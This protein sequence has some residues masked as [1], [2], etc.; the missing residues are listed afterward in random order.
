MAR[1]NPKV[2]LVFKKLF[3]SEENTDILLSLINSILPADRQIAQ[4]TLKNPYN[5][6]DY[7]QGKLSILDIKAEDEHGKQYDIEMQLQGSSFYG[8]RTLFYWA[9][10]FGSQL[11][12]TPEEMELDEDNKPKLGYAELK[13]CIVISLMDFKMFKDERY[14]RCFT[15][16][17]LDTNEMPESLDY[18][19]LYFIELKKFTKKLELVKTVLERWISFLNYAYGYS[20][21]NLPDE[22]SEI[23]E[24]RKAAR[25]L[26]IMHFAK[27]ERDHY[28]SQQKFWLDAHSIMRERLDQAERQGLAK[29]LQKG[30]QEGLEK[31]I[32]KGLEEG[33]EK[34][35]KEGREKG[36]QEGKEK[37][38]QESA[39]TI[40]KNLI[41][42][43]MDNQTIQKG[44]GLTRDQIEELRQELN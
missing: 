38:F 37:G 25:R 7:L 41:Q 19:E 28:E 40:A 14:R 20:Q 27:E 33:L 1:L 4:L 8:K 24:I 22:L 2:D 34:G 16:K 21:T 15:I 6:S 39:V 11:D 31:G 3:G 42:L 26:E 17:D 35:L 13:K 30:I 43:G 5:L 12:G 18:L 9:K 29:G 10:M 23:Q 32:E 36:L 44:T